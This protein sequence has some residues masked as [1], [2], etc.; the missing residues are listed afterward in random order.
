MAAE[1]SKDSSGDAEGPQAVTEGGDLKGTGAG[2]AAVEKGNND[3]RSDDATREESKQKEG[4]QEK[5]K[6]EEEEEEELVIEQPLLTIKEVFV[7]QVPPLRASSGHRAE[8]WGLANPVF[9]GECWQAS[10]QQQYGVFASWLLLAIKELSG[11]FGTTCWL[12][13]RHTI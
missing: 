5:D 10:D 11:M 7:Y 12:R 13:R 6:G 9:T 3:V 4:H 2:T 8:E 1:K